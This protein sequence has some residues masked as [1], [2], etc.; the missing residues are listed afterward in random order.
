MLKPFCYPVLFSLAACSMRPPS[1]H[2]APSVGRISQVKDCRQV[3]PEAQNIYIQW[4]QDRV[5]DGMPVESSTIGKI[6]A[7]GTHESGG[8]RS[9]GV[10]FACVAGHGKYQRFHNKSGWDG[11]V[12]ANFQKVKDFLVKSKCNHCTNWGGLQ[13]SADWVALYGQLSKYLIDLSANSPARL[14]RICLTRLAYDQDSSRAV[15]KTL[16]SLHGERKKLPEYLAVVRGYAQQKG[17]LQDAC[18]NDPSCVKASEK[19]GLWLSACPRVS[20]DISYGIIQ[21]GKGDNYWGTWSRVGRYC[22]K[23]IAQEIG[24]ARRQH[25]DD[26]RIR[27]Q[28]TDLMLADEAEK[29]SLLERLTQAQAI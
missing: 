25:L 21:M 1:G 8:C 18:L 23:M 16:A 24:Y 7:L 2:Y 27:Y 3:R 13:L 5:A 20:L 11:T 29:P 26:D 15:K 19:I 10:N 4:V 28:N 12:L 22:T 17:N 14:N 9:G 6:M